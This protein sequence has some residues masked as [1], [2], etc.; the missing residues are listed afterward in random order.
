MKNSKI[1]ALALLTVFTFSSCNNDDPEVV[2]EE[3]VITTVTTTLTA[4]SSVITLTSRDLDGDGPN[5]PV[6]TASGDLK[7]NTTY[8]GTTTFLNEAVKP[9]DDITAEVKEEGEDHQLFYQAPT[10]VGTFTYGDTDKNGKPIGLTFT[11]KTE[12]TATTG[13]I[14]VVLRHLPAKSASGVAT[15]DITNAGGATDAS[16]TFPVKVV[17]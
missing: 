13:N 1:L 3:E 14:T 4:G 2:N 10:A 16:V 5:A 7:I 11:L 15:G 8:N 6:V 12:A 9:A 17:N